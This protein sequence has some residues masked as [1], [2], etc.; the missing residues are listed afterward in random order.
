MRKALFSI[1]AAFAFACATGSA[2]AHAHLEKATPA[3]GATVSAPSAIRLEF[4]EDIEPK[5]SGLTLTGPGGAASLG[6][7]TL[8]P[9]RADTL[10]VPVEK[11][12]APGAYTVK[13]RALSADSHKTQ[14]AF[15][16]TVK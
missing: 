9:G 15:S 2:F 3:A 4:S 13:W 1:V 8:A 14:G 12:L 5:F 6:T 7:A 11:P 16:F 10:V